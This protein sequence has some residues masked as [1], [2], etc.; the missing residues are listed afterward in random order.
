MKISLFALSCECTQ[1]T[2]L[3]LVCRGR[4]G[5]DRMTVGFT[6]TYSISTYRH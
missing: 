6:T 3:L 4:R 5:R 1:D 2:Y